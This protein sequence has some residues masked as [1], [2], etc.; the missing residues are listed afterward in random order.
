M[1]DKYDSIGKNYARTRAADFRISARLVETLG[2]LPGK[3]VLDVGAGTGNYSYALAEEGYRVTALEPSKTMREQAKQHENLSWFDGYAEELPFASGSFDGVVM[4]LC[5]H[6]FSDWRKALCEAI[7]VTDKGPIAIF[8]FDPDFEPHFW[9]LDYF[10]AFLDLDRKSFPR[11]T[12]IEK[13]LET[14]TSRR[15]EFERFSLP[16]DLKDHFLAAAWARPEIYL[17]E[18]YHAGISSFSAIDCAQ[19]DQG[20]RRLQ[21]DLNANEWQE[22]YGAILQ[23]NELDVGYVFLKL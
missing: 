9:L 7:R 18:D 13:F 3:S 8:T 5:M 12:D 22:K 14:N 16:R 19:R 21:Q 23:K 6:H 20:L 4:T 10:P 11:L 1:R 17:E 2:L 15:L